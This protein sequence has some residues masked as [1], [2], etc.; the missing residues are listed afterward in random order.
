MIWNE[1][2][3]QQLCPGSHKGLWMC[4]PRPRMSENQGRVQ[5]TG[6]K[7]LQE[8]CKLRLIR[9]LMTR[10]WWTAIKP[11][12]TQSCWVSL[13]FVCRSLSRAEVWQPLL[14]LLSP[15]PPSPPSLSPQGTYLP[16][17]KESGLRSEIQKI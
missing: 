15:S 6:T 4:P 10:S 14:Y 12:H 1:G 3:L 2:I 8:R 11:A 5:R 16:S 17:A 7:L 13:L 9:S